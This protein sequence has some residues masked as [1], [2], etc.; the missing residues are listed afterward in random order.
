MQLN[1]NGAQAIEVSERTFG[2]EFNETLVHQAVVAYMAGGRQGTRAQKTR[3]E[4]S[5]GGKK[6]WRQKGTGRAR[7]GTIRSPIWRSGGTTF[8]A[9]P[10]DHSQ[11]LNKKMYRAAMRSI[12][13]ELVRQ[14]RLVVV[15]DFAVAAPKTKELAAKLA[16]LGL[17]DVLIVSE[18]VDQNLYLAARNL[19]HVDVRDVQ[20]SDPVSLIAYDKVLITVSAVKKFE[21]LLA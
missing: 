2:G 13:A 9:K 8:A 5:G 14:D 6:P 4:V 12:L 19:P 1:V 10:Q 20:G 3:S 11:K 16:G 15:D 18:S 21:E 17:N 7:A